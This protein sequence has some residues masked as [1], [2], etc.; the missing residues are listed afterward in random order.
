MSLSEY[1]DKKKKKKKNPE[2]ANRIIG[3]VLFISLV[4]RGKI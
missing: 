2:K 1:G 4:A 3:C